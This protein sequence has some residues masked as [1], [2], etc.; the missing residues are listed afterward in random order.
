MGKLRI[1]LRLMSGRW[2]TNAFCFFFYNFF[3][4]VSVFVYH[5]ERTAQRNGTKFCPRPIVAAWLMQHPWTFPTTTL[6]FFMCSLER[7]YWNIPG[8]CFDIYAVT[9]T[10]WNSRIENSFAT[11]RVSITSWN[12]RGSFRSGSLSRRNSLRSYWRSFTS[13]TDDS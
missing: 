13:V 4:G 8:T 6:A 1:D 3:F 11:N 5:L 12:S 9:G 10:A 2:T 7:S